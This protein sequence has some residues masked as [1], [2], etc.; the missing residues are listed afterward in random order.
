MHYFILLVYEDNLQVDIKEAEFADCYIV[1]IYQ[2]Y[3]IKEKESIL[4]RQ[5]LCYNP[6]RH[7][8]PL[9]IYS[10]H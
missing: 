6:F 10:L 4:L 7:V 2:E 1:Y 9:S 3:I 8:R 5:G